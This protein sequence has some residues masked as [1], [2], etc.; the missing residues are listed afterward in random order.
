MEWSE[1][2]LYTCF[3]VDP[4]IDEEGLES[5]YT[6]NRAGYKLVFTVW[7]YEGEVHILLFGPAQQSSVTEVRLR[8][9]I[10]IRYQ[11]EGDI[12]SLAF[13]NRDYSRFD[14]STF[15]SLQLRVRPEF[16][17]DVTR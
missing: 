14:V 6:V 7:P 1:V 15:H 5:R 10:A 9:C 16:I 12:E 17:I 8:R 13:R 2:D 4:E 11:R 3:E